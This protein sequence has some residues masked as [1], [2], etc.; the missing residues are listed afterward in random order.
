MALENGVCWRPKDPQLRGRY[1]TFRSALEAAFLDLT[2]EHDPFFDS[3]PDIWPQ[4]F[5]KLAARP[6]RYEDG[7]IVLYVKNPPTLYA[8]RMK[9]G[10]IRKTLSELP[11][12]PKKI[13]LKLE[14]HSS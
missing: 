5:P 8:M 2:T 1:D 13:N 7:Q 12:A 14:I 6:G 10:M 11:N 4:L 9:L 3:L